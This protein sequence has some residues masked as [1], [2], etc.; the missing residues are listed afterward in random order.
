[1]FH[2]IFPGLTGLWTSWKAREGLETEPRILLRFSPLALL[3][4]PQIHINPSGF[5]RPLGVVPP[6][7][8]GHL[9]YPP[10]PSYFYST[11]YYSPS[12]FYPDKLYQCWPP[13]PHHTY[14]GQNKNT[15][16]PKVLN[17]CNST[18]CPKLHDKTRQHFCP[19]E[20]RWHEFPS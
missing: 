15:R 3:H 18:G 9:H 1:M 20:D 11:P 2:L 16:W 17:G 7:S 19:E 8:P 10:S 4:Q 12:H 14:G 5:H 6:A 13:P